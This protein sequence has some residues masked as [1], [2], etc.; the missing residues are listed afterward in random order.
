MLLMR[1]SGLRFVKRI[2]L[3]AFDWTSGSFT[4]DDALHA[5][6]MS[7]IVPSNAKLVVIK[8]SV[9]STSA[10][11]WAGFGPSDAT[12][13][14]DCCITRCPPTSATMEQQIIIPITPGGLVAYI[15]TTGLLTMS[16]AVQGWWL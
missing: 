13:H 9:A 7:S 8:V 2:G 10:T 16:V 12:T 11:H 5:F 4:K 14:Y 6:D 3:S 15:A 1:K